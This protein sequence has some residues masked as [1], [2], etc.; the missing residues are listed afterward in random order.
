M[1]RLFREVVQG[2]DYIHHQGL[3]HRD[4]KPGNVFIDSD[5][6]VNIGDFG[7]ATEAVSAAAAAPFE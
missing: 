3:I 2:L 1:W 5:D 7:L 4:L 6:R